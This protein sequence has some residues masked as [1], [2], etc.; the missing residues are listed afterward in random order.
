MGVDEAHGAI[1]AQDSTEQCKTL[2]GQEGHCSYKQGHRNL[3]E[4]L[5]QV[6]P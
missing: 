4:I 1:S 6:P 5:L 3:I 2:P